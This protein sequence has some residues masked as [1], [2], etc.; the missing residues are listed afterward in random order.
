MT[1]YGRHSPLRKLPSLSSLYW[2]YGIVNI[3]GSYYVHDVHLLSFQDDSIQ[4]PQ[5]KDSSCH[6]LVV[7]VAQQYHYWDNYLIY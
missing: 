6:T 1:V 5:S 3:E 4:L 2:R 7:T